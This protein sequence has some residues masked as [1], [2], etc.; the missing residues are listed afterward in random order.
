MII[1]L[2]FGVQGTSR[3]RNFHL[4]ILTLY[5]RPQVVILELEHI[6]SLL[7]HKI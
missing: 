1:F 2:L 3:N 7:S 5:L 6:L 4:A